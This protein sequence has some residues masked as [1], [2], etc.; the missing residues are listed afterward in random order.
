MRT[1]TAWASAAKLVG[2]HPVIIRRVY[3]D[4]WC[5]GVEAK[6]FINLLEQGVAVENRTAKDDA[7][8]NG[9]N[10]LASVRKEC[11]EYAAGH[12]QSV[13]DMD[14]QWTADIELA[15]E[16]DFCDL[17]D[18][19]LKQL[20]AIGD[21]VMCCES[22]TY[23]FSKKQYL[24]KGKRYAI[25]TLKDEG[26][27]SFGY[28]TLTDIPSEVNH[29]SVHSVKSLWRNGAEIWNWWIA[30][31]NQWLEQTP[32]PKEDDLVKM[33]S[34]MTRMATMSAAGKDDRDARKPKRK[35]CK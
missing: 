14:A 35:K 12:P 34:Q 15:K 22:K 26:I 17:M 30:Y 19:R 13:K 10:T 6:D 25:L 21:E 29:G 11:A 20:I 18:Y 27:S 7:W 31:H 3:L 2:T 16:N 8:K 33:E 1:T 5:V 4:H 24:T 23:C 9:S 28:T 32:D